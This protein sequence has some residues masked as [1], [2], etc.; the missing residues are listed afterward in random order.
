MPKMY[1]LKYAFKVNMLLQGSGV[2][3][4]SS[5]HKN[6]ADAVFV[7]RAEGRNSSYL[8]QEKDDTAG[9]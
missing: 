9:R 4:Y 7:T 5:V 8:L 3:S 6:S 1:I 2:V